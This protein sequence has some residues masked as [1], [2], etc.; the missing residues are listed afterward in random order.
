MLRHVVVFKF[1]GSVDEKQIDS[2]VEAFR[3]LQQTVPKIL[4]I[5][6]G[7]NNSTENFNK[8]LTHAFIV[9]FNNEVDRN[10]YLIDPTH[11]KFKLMA[12]P[13]VAD[14]FVV[15]FTVD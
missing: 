14:I 5:D 7:V 12:D 11:E 3:A 1:K 4:S 9:T 2:I 10:A 6:F 15:D 8:G 13:F